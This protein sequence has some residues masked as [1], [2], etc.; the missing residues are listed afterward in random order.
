MYWLCLQK[1]KSS[2]GDVKRRISKI[3]GP[4]WTKS[5]A[6]EKNPPKRLS[7]P[8]KLQTLQQLLHHDYWLTS[9]T[10]DM[11]SYL[12]AKKHKEID[13]FQ[14][15]LPFSALAQGGIVGTPTKPFVQ[16]INIRNS[17][18]ITISNVFCSQNQLCVYDSLR[19][20]LDLKTQ[21]I[22]SWLLRPK[23]EYF[24]VFQPP[25]QQQSNFSNCGLFAIAFAYAICQG[26]P[27]EQCGFN[28]GRLR[29]QL[30]KSITQNNITFGINTVAKP[31]I[32]NSDQ[33]R[34]SV[35]CV[36]R[37]AHYRELMVQCSQCQEWYHPT[38]IHIPKSVIGSD[39]TWQCHKSQCRGGTS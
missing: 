8:V 11:A 2:G 34:I 16:I 9:D 25:V 5:S 28:E 39:E 29:A 24:E 3:E 31:A 14:S 21:Q 32:S 20:P 37:T 22:L 26:H 30:Y 13:G 33:T 35:Y 38:C 36:C 10:I 1:S 18:W 19:G 27:P 15:V 6:T 12:L 7:R 4:I 23:E 17:H